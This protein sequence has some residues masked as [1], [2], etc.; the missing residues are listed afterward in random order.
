MQQKPA[1]PV[2]KPRLNGSKSATFWIQEA[3]HARL[4]RFAREHGLSVSN[5]IN[6]AVKR[7]LDDPEPFNHH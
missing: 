6:R 4:K 2:G 7:F 1:L 3:D 5:V